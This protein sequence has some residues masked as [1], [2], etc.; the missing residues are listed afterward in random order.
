MLLGPVYHLILSSLKSYLSGSSWFNHGIT[1]GSSSCPGGRVW[2]EGEGTH[3][4]SRLFGFQLKK[5]DIQF[6]KRHFFHKMITSSVGIV[7]GSDFERV[8][9]GHIM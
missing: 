5:S 9:L 8:A 2:R 6:K 1:K 7:D 4:L 3:R